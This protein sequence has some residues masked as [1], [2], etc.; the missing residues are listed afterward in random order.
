MSAIAGTQL[1]MIATVGTRLDTTAASA[2]QVVA[3]TGTAGI[4]PLMTS[5]IGRT[6]IA[7]TPSPLDEAVGSLRLGAEFT[8]TRSTLNTDN[9]SMAENARSQNSGT[10][11]AT[12]GVQMGGFDQIKSAISPIANDGSSGATENLSAAVAEAVEAA[13]PMATAGMSRLNTALMSGLSVSPRMKTAG[14]GI[15]RQPM[16]G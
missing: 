6:G 2:I 10:G 13:A 9:P 3:V 1:A 14:V 7:R 15:L 4:S 8:E 11:T 5:T 12:A 16:P